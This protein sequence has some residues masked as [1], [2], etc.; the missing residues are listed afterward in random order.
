MRLIS[1][2]YSLLIILFIAC[3]AR[4][5]SQAYNFINYDVSDGLVHDKVLD[6]T[7]DRFGNLWIATLLGGISK[8]NGVEFTNFTIR[9][10]LASN[11]VRDILVDKKGNVWAATAK[12]LSMYNGTK[13]TNYLY[14]SVNDRSNLSINV[15]EEGNEG[16]WFSPSTGGVGFLDFKTKNTKYYELEGKRKKDKVI[17][18]EVDDEGNV[19]L[20]SVVN[21]LFK[22][23][24]GSF[25][26]FIDNSVFKGFLLSVYSDVNGILWLGSNKG[27]LRYDP[28]LPANIN[29]FFEP[30][31]GT[32]IKSATVKDTSNFWALSAF[33]ILK[34][35]KGEVK[36]FGSAEGFTDARVNVFYSDREENFWTGTDGKGMYKLVNE[37]FL[38]FNEEHG[39]TDKP[40][41]SIIKDNG[42]TY[43]IGTFGDGILTY[44]GKKFQT[45]DEDDYD[46]Y[47]SCATIDNDGNLWFGTRASGIIKYDGAKL[48]KYTTADGLVFNSVRCITS[49]EENNIWIGTA[50]GLSLLTKGSFTNYTRKNGLY[51]NVIWNFQKISPGKI[52]VVTRKGL[53]YFDEASLVEGFYEEGIFNKRVNMALADSAGNYWIAYSGHGLLYY[54][55]KTKQKATINTEDGLT[56]DLI[57][58]IILDKAG[59]LIVGSERGVDKV[60]FDKNHNVRHIKNYGNIEGF[61]DLQT[62][63]NSFYKDDNGDIWFGTNEGIYKY[64]WYNEFINDKSPITYLS[65]IKLFYS[66]VDWSNYSDTLTQWFALPLSLELPYNKNNL[67]IEYFGNSLMNPSKVK[68]KFR[69]NGLESNWS[70]VTKNTEAVYTNLDPGDYTFEVMAA[71]SDGQW[72]EESTKFSFAIIPPF[73]MEPWFFAIVFIL[74]ILGFKLYHDYRISAKLN[75]VLTIE[76][77]RSE[78]LLKV[79]KRMARDFHDNM[80][81]QLASITVFA[82]LINIKLKDKSEEI[83]H[84]LESIEKH[85]KSLF[86]GT[87]DFI[88]SMDP[89][90]DNLSEIFNYI[91]D[92][93]EDLFEEV[94]IKF[95]S[96]TVG[97]NGQLVPVPSG[98]SRQIVLI[99]KEAMTNAFK[100]AEATEVYFNL[101]LGG[102]NF[103]IELSDNG[104]GIASEK[105]GKGKGFKNMRSRAGQ[106]GCKIEIESNPKKGGTRISLFGATES[107]RATNSVTNYQKLKIRK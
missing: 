22:L 56:S 25:K 34:V 86:N 7:E 26:K 82:N 79:R 21:G 65:S 106:I 24:D 100:H 5:Y 75:K 69:L 10:G 39:L 20:V 4:V 23:E 29:N 95:L 27:L 84:L 74:L 18:I 105:L 51:D 45:L 76:R 63:T 67:V 85:T 36:N 8:Y 14:D 48:E 9:D 101:N 87:K 68:Y 1:K 49:D 91:K 40:I 99:F 90:S 50:N 60:Y 66:E 77:I 37:T 52:M 59:N 57:F 41:T 19:W 46:R 3:F 62:M 16:I 30:L 35:E 47:I 31:R 98:Y 80:G 93:G 72:N 61:E 97:L 11:F 103:V 38:Y 54:N 70:P 6:I 58:N 28:N 107:I 2:R 43:Y 17:D 88:W 104:N 81:N 96:E 15:I 92:F 32:F 78:E 73:W 83:N 13:F 53:N 44:D 89:E 71:N 64:Q 12:S 102:G 94:D 42:G 33:G 55:S